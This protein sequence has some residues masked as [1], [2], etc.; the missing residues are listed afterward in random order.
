M[1]DIRPEERPLA[2]VLVSGGLDSC[3]CLA[4]AQLTYALAA[5]HVNYGQRTE[6]KELQAFQALTD[7]YRISRRLQVDL[8][9]LKAIG[10]SSLLDPTLPVETGL[11]QPGVVPSTYVPF[12]N[13]HLLAVAVSWAEVLAAQAVF[14]GAVAADSSGYP[15]C[16]ENFFEL[17]AAA[18]NAG[19]NSP[20]QISIQT[21]LIHMR[22]ADIVRRGGE[23]AAPLH[24]TWSC[25]TEAAEACGRCES[26]QLRL[27]G[28]AE[29]GQ[30]DPIPYVGQDQP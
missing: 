16:N 7:H 10:G 18:A 9:H 20:T 12:R 15:D 19:T 30:V 6:A 13:A 25:Y 23:L 14:I 22:K 28:F 4:E 2:V 17:F 26:C 3:V 1:A 11:P 27:R 5:L 29:A 8:T 24:L 21:P